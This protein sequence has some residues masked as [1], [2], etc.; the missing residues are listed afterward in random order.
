MLRILFVIPYKKVEES[1]KQ[2]FRE[3]LPFRGEEITYRISQAETGEVL[4]IEPAETDV[5]IARGFTAASMKTSLP[6]IELQVSAYDMMKAAK[7]CMRSF[8]CRKIVFVGTTNM[9]FGADSINEVLDGVEISGRQVLDS[10]NLGQELDNLVK[11]GADAV[12]GGRGVVQYARKKG[13]NCVL[14]ESGKESIYQAV[15]EAITAMEFSRK[16]KEKR[17]YLQAIMDY[18]FEGIISTDKEGKIVSANRFAAEQLTQDTGA[19]ERLTGKQIERYFPEIRLGKNSKKMLAKLVSSGRRK[20]MVNCVQL[21]DKEKP[22]GWIITFRDIENIQEDESRIR[23]QLHS[24]GLCAK[25]RFENVIHKSK[26]MR[27]TIQIARKYARAESNVFIHGETGT[28][29]ELFAQ[30]IHNASSRRDGPFLAINCAALPESLLESELFGYVEGA[31]TGAVKGGKAGLFELAH[32]GTLFLDEIG[33]MAIKL[34]ARLLRV[35]QEREIMRL[36]GTQVIPV[37]V[38]IIAAANRDMRSAV[39]EGAFRQD[40]LYRIDVLRLELPPLRSREKDVLELAGYYISKQQSNAG[41]RLEGLNE[42][43]QDWV[44]KQPWEGNVRELKNFCERLC[45]LCE[46]EEADMTDILSASGLTAPENYNSGAAGKNMQEE[47]DLIEK[48]LKEHNYSR[49][50]TAAA[51]NIDTSTLWRKMRKY[52]IDCKK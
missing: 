33:D 35:I 3:L 25:Y 42:E 21:T 49:K 6:K 31:F 28:G 5:V 52:G 29:K 51:M 7:M 13:I 44:L 27:D 23:K 48:I 20:F 40:L 24:K 17:E 15:E 11:N 47:K 37:N 38:R 16:E 30:S 18:S 1:V 50:E 39:K 36:G 2:A 34:Q 8:R 46:K 10:A 19:G 12:I 32:N 22:E 43:A 4:E 26:I 41:C 9:I 14:L 45:V